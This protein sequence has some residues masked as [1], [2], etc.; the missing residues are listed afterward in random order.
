M[1]IIANGTWVYQD[2]FEGHYPEVIADLSTYLANLPLATSRYALIAYTDLQGKDSKGVL[3]YPLIDIQEGYVINGWQHQTYTTSADGNDKSAY[4]RD[5]FTPMLNFIV[6]LTPAA[7]AHAKLSMSDMRD[8]D[9]SLTL[10]YP[11]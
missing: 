5:L 3:Y 10:W 6:S 11:V 1:A 2:T 4:E 8:G 9:A 7:L